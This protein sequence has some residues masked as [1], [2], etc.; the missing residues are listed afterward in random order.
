MNVFEDYRQVFEV[1]SCTND[2]YYSQVNCNHIP[3]ISKIF[4]TIVKKAVAAYIHTTLAKSLISPHTKKNYKNT[5]ITT[6]IHH[7]FQDV[8]SSGSLVV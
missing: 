1:D 6:T 3:N 4:I 7:K 5:P 8:F 2:F